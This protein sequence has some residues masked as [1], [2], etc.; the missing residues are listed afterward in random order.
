MWATKNQ[1]YKITPEIKNRLYAYLSTVLKSKGGKLYIAGGHHDHVHCFLSLPP[2]LSLSEM[3]QAVK[4]A[5]SRWIKCQPSI[6]RAFAWEE[7][8][9][10]IS[11]QD[12][13][14]DAICSY[15]KDEGSRH[16]K[17]SYKDELIKLL[18]AQSIAYQDE[19]VCRNTHCKLL[20]HLIWSTK[21]RTLSLP[22]SIQPSLYEK[23][24]DIVHKAGGIVHAI[25]GIED[26]VHLLFEAPR[27]MALADVVKQIKV[28]TSSWLANQGSSWRDFEWQIGYGAF[29]IS[30]P[31]LEAVKQYIMQQEEH[32]KS[33]ST[34]NEWNEFL[35][36]KGWNYANAL[37]L[38][39]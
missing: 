1:D 27:N 29:S 25:G 38:T 34:T 18:N 37:Q 8:Y 28:T 36:K 39:L 5:S 4:S 13:R 19:F 22:K 33:S 35:I 32:H 15:I 11:V 14:V 7:G 23:I 6:D 16:G 20:I 10:A 2:T 12:D 17:I 24:S 30:L 21:K 9:T 3:M 31:T 26:H